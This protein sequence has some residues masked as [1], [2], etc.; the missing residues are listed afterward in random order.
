MQRNDL[1]FFE[2]LCFGGKTGSFLRQVVFLVQV[3]NLDIRQGTGGRG[4]LCM[5]DC[6]NFK[7]N[8]ILQANLNCKV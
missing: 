3:V 7:L 5:S 6:R 4:C 8:K 2:C 1:I